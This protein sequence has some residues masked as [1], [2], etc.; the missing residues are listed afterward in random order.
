[1]ALCRTTGLALALA[2]IVPLGGASGD[3]PLVVTRT[4]AIADFGWAGA[5]SWNH[6][7]AGFRCDPDSPF[8][9]LDSVWL[10]VAGRGGQRYVVQPDP[11]LNVVVSE[12]DAACV[13][14]GGA[15]GGGAGVA[16]WGTLSARAA[17]LQVVGYGSAAL[18]ASG[19][20]PGPGGSFQAT[21]G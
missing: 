11:S 2:I 15:N 21:V 9:G 10:D 8:N 19:S 3:E 1:M 17:F 13:S 18:G 20:M 7:L 16:E 14:V 4:I 5:F 12:Y 6:P